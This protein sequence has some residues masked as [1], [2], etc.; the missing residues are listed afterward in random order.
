M[1]GFVRTLTPEP[2]DVIPCQVWNL[3]PLTV[4]AAFALWFLVRDVARQAVG[5]H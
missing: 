5:R 4:V 2:F 1:C 3:M